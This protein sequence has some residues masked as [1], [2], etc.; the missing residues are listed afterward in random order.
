MTAHTDVGLP[1][2]YRTRPTLDLAKR[3]VNRLLPPGDPAVTD[4]DIAAAYAQHPNNIRETLFALF[5]VHQAR[6]GLD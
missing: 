1:T 2:I 5:D 3:I 6:S 4:S